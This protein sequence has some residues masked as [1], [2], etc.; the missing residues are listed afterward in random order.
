VN[1]SGEVIEA[2]KH[3]KDM[4]GSHFAEPDARTPV[5]DIASLT[6]R[7]QGMQGNVTAALK[8]LF[9]T[10]GSTVVRELLFRAGI[11]STCSASG[12]DTRGIRSLNDALASV[13]NDLER[14]LARTYYRSG[15]D[16]EAIPL[17]FS[18]I[19]LRHAGPLAERTF[20]DINEAIRRFVIGRMRVEGVERTREH[21]ARA[22]GKRVERAE[23]TLVA[24]RRE[25]AWSEREEEY[26][27]AGSFILSHV[28]SLPKGSTSAVLHDGPATMEVKLDAAL[29]PAQN[30]QRYFDKA[31]KTRLM[32]AQAQ[33]RINGLEETVATG[34]A[35][36]SAI[37]NIHTRHALQKFMEDSS[38]ELEV[39][40]LSSKGKEQEQPPFRIFTVDGG[41]QVLAGKSSANNDLLTMKY[42][43]PND[44]W[45]HARGSSG[46]HVVLRL[47]TG[48]GEPSKKAKEQAAGIAA[49]YSK[50]RNAKSVPVAMTE[51][52]YVRK[53]KGASPG[54]VTLERERVIFATPS[55]PS[56]QQ[57]S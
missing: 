20:D 5:Y 34:T 24:I 6:D 14:P 22:V 19:P 8:A 50:M 54:T 10:L 1:E 17:I 29:T 56:G 41:F 55:L 49:Y 52:K 12:L 3:A 7:L 45:F 37:G 23:R 16:E 38:R 35:L 43:K 13:V 48:A 21:V 32:R 44:L 27:R 31:K 42:A 18:I 2:F 36:L 47:A 40:G 57:G 39:F 26:R 53:P 28:H 30:A 9:P 4:V 25:L 11:S 46:S 15:D 33:G 51:R